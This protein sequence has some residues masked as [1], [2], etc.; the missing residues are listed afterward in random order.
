MITTSRTFLMLVALAP[1]LFGAQPAAEPAK[2]AADQPAPQAKKPAPRKN[3]EK[4]A[5]AEA[6]VPVDALRGPDEVYRVEVLNAP[7]PL[8][9]EKLQDIPN[10]M[11]IM[12]GTL[13][14][15]VQATSVKEIL[16]YL[17]TTQFQE[18]QGSEVLR[19]ATRGM[20]GSNYQN[21]KFDGMTI[22][23]TGPNAMEQLQQVEVLSGTPSA[24]YGPANP[25]GMFNFVSKRPTSEF[26]GRFNLGYDS[27]NIYVA[28]ADLSGHLADSDKINYRLN[29]LDSHGTS[30]VSN[31]ELDRKLAS[32]A[33][34]IHPDRDTRIELNLNRYDLT[35]KGFPGW[36]TFGQ[37]TALPAAPDPTRVGYGQAYAGVNMA[38]EI[39]SARLIQNLGQNWVLV[40]GVLDQQVF[41]NINTPVNNLT[42]NKG[43]YTSSLANGFAPF[44]GIVSN[45]A[46]LTGTFSTGG[47]HHDLTVGTTGFT[48]T[49]KSP[50]NS[51]KASAV[52]LG[53]ASIDN[54]QVFAMNPAGLPDVVDNYRSS[55]AAQQGLN[56]SDTMRFTD[57]WAFKLALSQDWMETRNYKNPGIETTTY[58]KN[59]LSPMPSLI[60]KPVE[61]VTTYLTYASSLQMGDIAPASNATTT[62]P[63]ANTALAPYRT[64]QWEAGVKVNLPS[65]DYT[66][67]LFRLERP[68]ANTDP[69]EGNLF[70]VLGNQVNTGVEATVIGKV[71]GDLRIFSGLTL[72]NPEMENS[73]V[74]GTNGR[75]YVGMPKLKANILFEYWVPSVQG[76]VVTA[77]WQYTSSRAVDDA[78]LYWSPSYSVFDLGG[79]YLTHLMGRPATWRLA[80][81]NLANEHYWSTIGPSNIIGSGSGNMTAHLGA[82]RTVAAS[83]SINF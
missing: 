8:G 60:Y 45:I 7:G 76:L 6:T 53:S 65:I 30:F 28:H 66:V 32:V 75:Q 2:T 82:P 29:L 22:F 57:Q 31:S 26:M 27:E 21:T 64:S 62:V 37:T 16:K 24:V 38:N 35:Q 68:F 39:Q 5:P 49:S 77:D 73:V 12:P 58:N 80:V 51:P 69:T 54:P 13:I 79:R 9:A 71:T 59:G 40:V 83:M 47:I 41:R 33:I 81:N 52:L 78:N 15:N 55:V 34:D 36:F 3:R 61:N 63:N 43:D 42:D 50:L 1:A 56:V 48:A 17:P 44:F 23:V 46:Y 14:E 25:A 72:M 20:Q 70:R 67:A 4:P 19:P 10:N 11:I 18:Q 74:P